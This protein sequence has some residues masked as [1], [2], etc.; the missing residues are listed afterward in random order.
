[1][2]VST[3]T[4]MKPPGHDLKHRIFAAVRYIVPVAVSAGLVAWLLQKVNIHQVIGI[5]RQG[6]DFSYIAVMMFLTMLSFIIRGIRWG[7]QLRAAGVPRM[8]PVLESVS[9]FG[10]YALNL[11]FPWLGEGW[12]CVF[13]S[14][15]ERVPLSTVIGTD[16]GDRGSDAVVIL[17]LAG[18]AFAV[19]RP[20]LDRFMARYAIGRDITR[21]TD[22]PRLWLAVIAV[23]S[24][25]WLIGHF[26]KRFRYVRAVE[27]SLTQIWDGFKV[28][29]TMKGIGAYVVLTAGIWI[30]YFFETYAC[31]YAFPFTRELIH[32]PG[33]CAGLIPGLVVFVFGSFSM[34]V[35]S[36]GGLGPWNIAVIFALSLYGIGQTEGAAYSVVVWGF[37]T[38]MTIL[39]GIFSA[40]Y[41]MADKRKNASRIAEK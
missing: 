11:V 37:Q 12:R 25:L 2:H 17:M 8:S 31:L 26:G 38:L 18:A 30:C 23:V 36:N 3:S 19:A 4:T 13:V 22:D 39:L 9:I 1:M 27:G 10:A 15:R 14:R 34:G 40:V 41:I 35:P 16:I 5:I 32:A 7:I 20:A 24:I 28:M 21:I 29:F 6:C 33:S